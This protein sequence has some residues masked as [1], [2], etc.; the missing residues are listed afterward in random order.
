MRLRLHWNLLALKLASG[1]WQLLPEEGA[2]RAGQSL[3]HQTLESGQS[4]RHSGRLI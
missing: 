4:P 3:D 2:G 1:A